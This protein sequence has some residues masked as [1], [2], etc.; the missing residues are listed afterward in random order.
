MFSCQRKVF[1]SC[2]IFTLPSLDGTHLAWILNFKLEEFPQNLQNFFHKE[3]KNYFYYLT[4]KKLA[5]NLKIRDLFSFMIVDLYKFLIYPDEELRY[6]VG[7]HN[8]WW[9]ELFGDIKIILLKHLLKNNPLYAKFFSHLLTFFISEKIDSPS[10]KLKQTS[11]VENP[12]SLNKIEKENLEEL[13]NFWQEFLEK[14]NSYLVSNLKKDSNLSFTE[15]SKIL[16]VKLPRSTLTQVKSISKVLYG[17][18]QSC[19]RAQVRKSYPRIPDYTLLDETLWTERLA[20]YNFI[21]TDFYS[22][23]EINIYVDKSGSMKRILKKNFSKM[24]IAKALMKEL[25]RMGVRIKKLY[26]F[27]REVE[28]IPLSKFPKVVPSGG[29]SIGRVIKYLYHQ[30]EPALIISDFEDRLLAEEKKLLHRVKNRLSTILI[31]D[32]PWVYEEWKEQLN[33]TFWLSPEKL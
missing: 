6:Q 5:E 15:T 20:H 27:D 7:E 8:Y 26:V 10:S 30:G 13:K 11:E 18:Y 33:F 31:S 1:S 17:F 12:S 4:G 25:L 23:L 22:R 21:D 29:T 9:Y 3:L 32:Y 19:F 14:I 24:D 2:E 28:R 16:K